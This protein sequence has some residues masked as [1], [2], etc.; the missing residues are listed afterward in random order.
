MAK[1]RRA[2]AQ[3]QA[4]ADSDKK[5]R[6]GVV[7]GGFG[8]CFF[9]HE[10]PNST[11]TAVCDVRPEGRDKLSKAFRCDRAYDDL[12]KLIA[13]ENVDAVAVFTPAPLHAEHAIRAMQAGKHVIS[14]VPAVCSLEDCQNLVDAVRRTGMTYMMAETSVYRPEVITA[15]DWYNQGRLGTVFYSELEYHHEGLMDL[16]FDQNGRPTWRHG[17]P[18]MYYPTHSTSILISVTGERLTEATAIGWGDGHDVLRTNR[19]N[20]PFW[21]TTGFF[22]TSEGH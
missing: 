6:I 22:T 13:D 20:N 9:W 5:V 7:G 18:P 19:Y 1:A 21:N 16:M 15:R 4:S 14:A 2:A 3:G 8:C 10:H 17:F 11:V 12:G